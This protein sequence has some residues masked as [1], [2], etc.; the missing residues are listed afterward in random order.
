VNGVLDMRFARVLQGG[1]LDLSIT[2]GPGAMAH[3]TTQSA[4]KIHRMDAGF[5]AATQRLSLAEDAY[6]EFLPGP[7]IPHRHSRFITH[8]HATVADG[9]TL[10]GAEILQRRACRS[11]RPIPRSSI[12]TTG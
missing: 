3:V 5:A 4:T 6:L 7:A 12:R 1:R 2:V 11:A 8:T 10:L 9:A